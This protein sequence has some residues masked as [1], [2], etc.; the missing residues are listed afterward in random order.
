MLI[1]N[2]DDVACFVLL[3]AELASL[4]ALCSRVASVSKQSVLTL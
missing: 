3:Q 2:L 1:V 4:C